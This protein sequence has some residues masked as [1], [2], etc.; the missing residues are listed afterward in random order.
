[1]KKKYILIVSALL[2]II[3]GCDSLNNK[4]SKE[5]NA[6]EQFFEEQE[7]INVQI[8][9]N[10]GLIKEIQEKKIIITVNNEDKIF[11]YDDGL[12]EIIS[13]LKVN[14]KVSV[15]Y[16]KDKN[17]NL[18]ISDLESYLSK[19][20]EVFESSLT[21]DKYEFDLNQENTVQATIQLKK[22]DG[23]DMTNIQ[24]VRVDNNQKVVEEV[25][26]LKETHTLENNLIQYAATFKV[27]SSQDTEYNYAVLIK[28]VDKEDVISSNQAVIY[29]HKQ[30]DEKEK[31][32]AIQTIN[33][34]YDMFETKMESESKKIAVKNTIDWVREQPYIKI[35][36]E[37]K[38]NYFIIKTTSDLEFKID[39]RD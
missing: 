22:I 35:I 17:N 16:Y 13:S 5:E 4:S 19:Y 7:N 36:M 23:L 30:V 39:L 26:Q 6:A 24:V 12:S 28:T 9:N 18:I 29:F 3:S 25:A 31:E 33:A 20:Q 37:E 2:L 27:Q 11:N 34:A 32:S 1:M 38:E 21:F 14:E 8:L 10:N 15:S